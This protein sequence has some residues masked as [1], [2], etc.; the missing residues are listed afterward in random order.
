M[1]R[2]SD[3][4]VLGQQIGVQA[5]E[6]TSRYDLPQVDIDHVLLALLVGGGPA[7]EVLRGQG[8][9]LD[10]ARRA[11]EQVRAQHIARLGIVPPAADPRP[12]RDPSLDDIDWTRRA[13]DVVSSNE[14]RTDL[15]LLAGLLD[16]PSRLAV[17]VLGAAGI[18]P[19]AVR[20]ALAQARASAGPRPP[21]GPTDPDWPAVTH[22]GFAPAPVEEVW[23]LVAD[24]MRRPEWDT[25]VGT[26]RPAGPGL[27]KMTAAMVR[28]DGRAVRR[29]PDYRRTHLR[30]IAYE[31]NELVGWEVTMP[32]RPGV[33]P[34]RHRVS[35]RLRPGSGGTS[36]DLALSWPRRTGWGRVR[37]TS[38]RPAHRAVAMLT[39]L[40]YATGISRTLR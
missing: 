24:P 14:D 31:A 8:L 11:T 25:S 15:G 39:L 16:E 7:G 2:L 38:L 18:D 1:S 28:P 10:A 35:V 5:L 12:I 40:Q 26:V 23:A 22:T 9:T 37:Q 36:V 17:E 27:W 30:L 20:V 4:F 21:A 19:D 3:V 33:R 34:S 13:L 32:D 29:R 6:E